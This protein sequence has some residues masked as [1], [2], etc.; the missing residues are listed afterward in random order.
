MATQFARQQRFIREQDLDEFGRQ[1]ERSIISEIKGRRKAG[2]RG[3]MTRANAL[4]AHRRLAERIE[5][6]KTI[7]SAQADHQRI[8]GRLG[9]ST[10]SIIALQKQAKRRGTQK[11]TRR[12]VKRR[13]AIAR[14]KRRRTKKGLRKVLKQETTI[15]RQRKKRKRKRKETPLTREADAWLARAMTQKGKTNADLSRIMTQYQRILHGEETFF[16]LE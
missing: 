14:K 12:I 15:R 10:R 5:E 3:L 9:V 7:T 1:I 16:E 2:R 8:A 4:E 6:R 11:E 13:T